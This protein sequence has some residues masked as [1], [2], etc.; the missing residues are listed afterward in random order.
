MGKIKTKGFKIYYMAILLNNSG[1]F[2]LK[3]NWLL[4]LLCLAAVISGCKIDANKYDPEV[5]EYQT[6]EPN[7]PLVRVCIYQDDE[8]YRYVK[9]LMSEN[10][11][12]WY[13]SVATYVPHVKI[14]ANNDMYRLMIGPSYLVLMTWDSKHEYSRQFV[15]KVSGE[16]YSNIV[17]L[18][19]KS[20]TAM[21]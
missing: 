5:L 7:Q 1:G 20:A 8:I 9:K 4:Y 11:E 15:K 16:A 13:P 17:V 18:I 2:V 10:M 19:K 14:R 21:E 3:R 12:G 6:F